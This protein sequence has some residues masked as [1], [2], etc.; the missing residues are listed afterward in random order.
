MYLY[1]S[2]FNIK[3]TKLKIRTRTLYNC[4]IYTLEVFI[5]YYFTVFGHHV[6][7]TLIQPVSVPF[8][9]ELHTVPKIPEQFLQ[10]HE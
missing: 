6:A 1:I 3:G 8:T 10:A 2:T 4:T 7:S 9:A 5:S